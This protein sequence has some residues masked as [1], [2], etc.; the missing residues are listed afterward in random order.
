VTRLAGVAVIGA[1]ALAGCQA[2]NT[3]T[4]YNDLVRASFMAGCT[5]N[6]PAIEGVTTTLASTSHCTCAYDVYVNNVPYNKDDKDNRDGGKKF[7]S[8]PSEAKTF[9]DLE[10]DLSD[11]PNKIN[12]PNELPQVVRDELGKCPTSNENIGTGTSVPATTVGTQPPGST[13]GPVPGTQP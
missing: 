1:V 12:D 10:H 5:G 9:V 6:V 13:V 2:D 7:A 8:Y 3:P 11:D 4:S